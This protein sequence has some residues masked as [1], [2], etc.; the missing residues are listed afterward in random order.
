MGGARR[1]GTLRLTA[2]GCGWRR[3]GGTRPQTPEVGV[4]KTMLWTLAAALLGCGGP[5]ADEDPDD[6]RDKAKPLPLNKVF[7]DSVSSSGDTSDWKIFFIEA[8]GL[9]TVTIHFDKADA[10]CEVFL[11]DK[12]GA[13]MAKEL[14]SANPYIELVR[15][16]EPARYFVHISAPRETCASQYS[17]EARVD[18]D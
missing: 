7:T 16:V 6:R 1:G 3:R 13:E 11:K 5:Q 2:L 15:R 4:R 14:Q 9:L 8:A 17:I 18:P 12:Y 10:G